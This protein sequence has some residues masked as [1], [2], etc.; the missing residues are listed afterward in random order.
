MI[1]ALARPTLARL[2]RPRPIVVLAAWS[3]LAVGFA[4][5]ARESGAAHGADHALVD[6]F[7]SLVLPLIAYSLVGTAVGARSLPAAAAPLVTFGARPALVAEVVVAIAVAGCAVVAAVLAAVVAAV[8]HGVADPP[9]VGDVATSAYAGALGGAAY[10][11]WFAFGATL[12]R[13]GGGRTALLVLDWLLGAGTGAQ[14]LVTPRAH[15]RAMLGGAAPL[16]LPERAS[17]AAL[18]AIAAAFAVLA[19]TRSRRP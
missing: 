16:G 9:V 3:A 19:V 4:L 2:R 14:A 17:A 11:A 8:A 10:A 13:R 15:L 5:I 1:G 18:V 6:A 7:G 12:G